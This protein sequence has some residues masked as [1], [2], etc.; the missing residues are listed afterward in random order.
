M[1]LLLA[2]L[3]A[4]SAARMIRKFVT[5]TLNRHVILGILY[6]DSH[7]TPHKA[8]W[9]N[10]PMQRLCR[11]IGDHEVL[12]PR[13]AELPSRPWRCEESELEKRDQ[14]IQDL[15]GQLK[16]LLS[17]FAWVVQGRKVAWE[18]KHSQGDHHSVDL[19]DFAG[20]ILL[21]ACWIG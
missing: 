12:E 9:N 15:L 19:V 6:S 17:V 2:R 4:T 14:E 11:E 18:L 7:W 3:V 5:C 21:K 20:G 13:A 10:L 8:C 1:V 16:E